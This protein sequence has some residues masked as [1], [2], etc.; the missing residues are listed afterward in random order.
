MSMGKEHTAYQLIVF[1]LSKCCIHKLLKS[2]SFSLFSE[3]ID[4]RLVKTRLNTGE[5]SPP[6]Q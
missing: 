2:A 3:I 6:K 1:L 4:I 5:L